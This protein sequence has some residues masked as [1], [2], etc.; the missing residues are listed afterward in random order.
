VVI[1]SGQSTY[2]LT[3]A[4]VDNDNKIDVITSDWYSLQ[5][6]V[7]RNLGQANFGVPPV[8]NS[9]NM[10][11][12]SLDASDIDADGDL[13]VVT[14][15]SSIT[16]VGVTVT[17][18]KNNGSGVFTTGVA[19]SIGGGGVQAKFRDLNGDGK[20]DL[21]FATAISSPPYNFHTA[22]NIGNGT[23]GPRQTWQMNACGWSDIDAFDLDNDG[24]LDAVVTEWLGCTNVFNSAQRIFISKNNGDGTFNA[25]LIKIVNPFPGS[26][27]AADFNNDGNIDLVTGQSLSIDLHLGTGTGDLQAPASFAVNKSP[28]DI[29]TGDFNKDGNV[30]IAACTEYNSEGMSVLLGNGNGTFQPAQNYDGAYSPDLRNESGI[31]SGDVDGDGDDDMIVGGAAS[32]DVSIYLNNGD[33]T[34]IFKMRYGLYYSAT[35]PF[36]GDFT[37]DGKNDII[38]AVSLPPSGFQGGVAMIKGKILPGPTINMKTVSPGKII[39]GDQKSHNGILVRNNPIGNYIDV[40]FEKIPIGKFTLLLTDLTGRMVATSEFTDVLQSEIRFTLGSEILQSGAYIL[41]A[42]TEGKEYSVMVVK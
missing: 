25:P 34:F 4:D 28:Y 21:I 9:N 16:A 11:P 38:A 22:I 15:A 14:S 17:V 18:Q 36:Y 5:V 27:A 31:T 29:L 37:G 1:P 13:D 41:S 2:T 40:E 7:H 30:D 24:D 23:F 3:T 12:G 26:V 32:N 33:G 39:S 35:S 20:P 42:V 10:F 19:Y 8:Y 6:T